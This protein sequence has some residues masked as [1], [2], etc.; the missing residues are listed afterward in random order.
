VIFIPRVE[1]R[2]ATCYNNVET[3]ALVRFEILNF[4]K[5]GILIM[6]E[7]L[8]NPKNVK[9]FSLLIA[10]VFIIG[11]FT[12][13]L[14]DSGFMAGSV[15][16]AAN[17]DSAIGVVN[18]QQLL[19][20]SPKLQE[21]RTAMQEEV[22]N[23]SSEFESKSKDMSEQEKRRYYQQLQQHLS[24]KEKELMDPLMKE[25][26]DAIKVVAG[27]KG[28]SVVVDKNV[29]IYGGADITAEVTKELTKA[30]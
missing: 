21:V 15:A 8:R 4:V 28:L 11:C 18:Y 9:F 22:K 19:A 16:Q 5:A 3:I 26:E 1:T 20:Q 7:K 25:I 29:V 30:K 23:T 2:A 27:K 6:M 12:L 14:S 17:N 10:A 24:V 13:A